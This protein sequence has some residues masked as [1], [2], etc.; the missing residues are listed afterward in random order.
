MDG[1]Q[2]EIVQSIG[3]TRTTI[4]D[5]HLNAL[6]QLSDLQAS[7]RNFQDSV[8]ILI[9]DVTSQLQDCSLKPGIIQKIACAANN[10]R[11]WY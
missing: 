9:D 10:V 6:S 4:H 5:C 11:C 2:A 8:R 1:K 7:I 3:D